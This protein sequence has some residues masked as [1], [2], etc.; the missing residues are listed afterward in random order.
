MSNLETSIL[1]SIQRGENIIYFD[2]HVVASGELHLKSGEVSVCYM[3][4][5]D[6]MVFASGD[7][8]CVVSRH[9]KVAPGELS[10][11]GHHKS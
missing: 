5:L 1:D 10:L 4:V 2:I 8:S 11:L 9:S 7:Q 3:V 6:D